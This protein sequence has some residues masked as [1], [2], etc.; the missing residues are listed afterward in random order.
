M[1]SAR[2]DGRTSGARHRGL[3]RH[4]VPRQRRGP[5]RFDRV[6]RDGRPSRSGD[7]A[8]EEGTFHESR[9]EAAGTIH[10]RPS[11]R[12]RRARSAGA[13]PAALGRRA[14]R[15]SDLIPSLLYRRVE[16]DFPTVQRAHP[17]GDGPFA[18]TL[19]GQR[20]Q[21]HHRAAARRRP[22]TRSPSTGPAWRS[23]PTRRPTTACSTPRSTR[24]SSSA[25]TSVGPTSPARSTPRTG[26]S[27]TAWSA[28]TA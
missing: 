20:R 28:S 7:A 23:S 17:I 12:S 16:P 15:E 6:Y 21:D 22:S 18:Q 4:Q 2:P 3:P 19:T 10:F 24:S 26:P 8:V 14:S 1:K 13:S 11:G 9:H 27:A 5:E 25:P